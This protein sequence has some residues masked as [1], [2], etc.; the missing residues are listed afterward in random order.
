MLT[1]CVLFLVNSGISELI[2]GMVVV[3]LDEYWVA[4]KLIDFTTEVKTES[5]R[6]DK[7]KLRFETAF[8]ASLSQQHFFFGKTLHDLYW[9]YSP[10]KSQLSSSIQVSY[11]RG[12]VIQVILID[13]QIS[14]NNVR[15]SLTLWWR[16]HIRLVETRGLQHLSPP[17]PYFARL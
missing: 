15:A 12:S 8:L 3:L 17:L 13:I 14:L 7:I 9:Q 10:S 1:F 6:I 16:I 4:G 5:T 2:W 11:W